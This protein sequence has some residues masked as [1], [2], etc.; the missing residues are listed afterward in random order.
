MAFCDGLNN[1]TESY[2]EEI[3]KLEDAILKNPHL[4]LTYFLTYMEKYESIFNTLLSTINTNIENN[5]H[6]C[7]ILGRL[8]NNFSCGSSTVVEAT[9]QLVINFRKFACN[10][11]FF[12]SFLE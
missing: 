8:L 2:R 11:L 7:L 3:L 6:G 12:V 4:S 9:N 5:V 10:K 1:V